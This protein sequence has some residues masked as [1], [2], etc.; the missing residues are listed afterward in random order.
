MGKKF[1]LDIETTRLA[2]EIRDCLGAHM[3][4]I[5]KSDTHRAC[6]TSSLIALCIEVGR[7][8]WLATSTKEVDESDF[9]KVFWNG[10]MKHYREHSR[11]YDS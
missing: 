9:D 7:L 11:D 2:N 8:R 3:L 4:K 6:I 5:S 1:D 10:V